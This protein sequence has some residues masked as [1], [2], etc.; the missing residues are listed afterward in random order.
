[1]RR[2]LEALPNE[3]IRARPLLAV[4]YVGA[5]MSTGKFDGVDALLRDAERSLEDVSIAMVV[6]D[7]EEFRRVPG[8]LAMYRAALARQLGDVAGTMEHARR[9]LDLVAEDDH[10]GRG[11]AAALLGLAYWSVGDL[12]AAFRWYGDGMASLERAGHHSDVVGGAVTMAG[13]RLAQ[14]R[15]TEALSIYERGLALATARG[16]PV[17]RGAADMHVGISEILRERGDLAG[18][19]GHLEASRQLGD[20]NG[21]LQNAS[22]SRVAMA[23]VLEAEGDLDE[24]LELL[25]EAERV[26]FAD[27]APNVRPIS[28]LRARIWITQGKL[29]QAWGWV[30]EN[31]LAATGDLSYLREYAHMTLARL[32]LAGSEGGAADP[33]MQ[34]ASDLLDRLLGEAERG[35]RWRSVIEL[36]GLR[37]LANARAG[38]RAA[39]LG[40]LDRAITLAEPDGY[41]RVFVDEGPPMARLLKESAKSSPARAY[42]RRVLASFGGPDRSA[43]RQASLEPLSER[44]L[45]VLRLLATDLGGPEIARE[46]FVSLNTMRTH[47]KSIYAKLGVSSRRAAVRRAVELELLAGA[48]RR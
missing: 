48:A 26:Y 1:M 21:M 3:L 6:R 15:M 44:E 8:A 17:L 24:A 41:L 31:S 19:R 4:G 5:L 47:T 9:G 2:W 13:I 22:R 43:H 39:A 12:D 34:D 28:A 20:E 29:S 30:R 45:D 33:A 18:A 11:G 10:V 42:V 46:L 14:G 16:R 38:D 40:A 7:E 23:R 37:A 32:L 36:L 27:F 35:G 25:G